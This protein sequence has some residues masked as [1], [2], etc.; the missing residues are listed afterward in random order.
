MNKEVIE[1]IFEKVIKPGY[2]ANTK[3]MNTETI[4]ILKNIS[5]SCSDK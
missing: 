3:T 2:S 5:L 1:N 4:D